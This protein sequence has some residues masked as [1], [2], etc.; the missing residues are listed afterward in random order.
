MYT[1][2]CVVVIA[3]VIVPVYVVDSALCLSWLLLV[4]WNVA[5]QWIFLLIADHE[6]GGPQQRSRECTEQMWFNENCTQLHALTSTTLTIIAIRF[7]LIKRYILNIFSFH[8]MHIVHLVSTLK[9]ANFKQYRHTSAH[10][11]CTKQL[12]DEFTIM[13]WHFLAKWL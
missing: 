10:K 7:Y 5:M 9:M 1:V 2:S 13:K 4:S 11:R 6:F 3:S 8:L 12:S